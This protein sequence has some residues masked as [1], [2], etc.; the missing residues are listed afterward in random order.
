MRKI[1]TKTPPSVISS[2]NNPQTLPQQVVTVESAYS[3]IGAQIERL[4][5]KAGQTM[6]SKDDVLI[7]ASLVKSLCE[8]QKNDR[9]MIKAHKVQESLENMT[10]EQLLELAQSVLTEAESE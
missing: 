4:R 2:I 6:L 3:I 9:Q 8:L 10:Q 7:L 1:V 5:I